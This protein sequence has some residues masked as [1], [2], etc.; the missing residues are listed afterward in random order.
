MKAK[1]EFLVNT[2]KKFA[3]KSATMASNS[4]CMYIYHQ[5]KMPEGVSKM[6]K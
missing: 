3:S 2:M 5:P 1:K 4:R 6:H